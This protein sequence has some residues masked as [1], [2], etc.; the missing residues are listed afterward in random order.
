MN[1]I[2]KTYSNYEF[3][4]RM[5]SRDWILYKKEL[6]LFKRV[7]LNGTSF[8]LSFNYLYSDIKIKMDSFYEYE[9]EMCLLSFFKTRKKKK[10]NEKFIFNNTYI[11]RKKISNETIIFFESRLLILRENVKNTILVLKYLKL[12]LGLF[13]KYR[14]LKDSKNKISDSLPIYT[15]EDMQKHCLNCSKLF[16]PKRSN[17]IYCSDVCS[18]EFNKEKKKRLKEFDKDYIKTAIWKKQK[19][20][21]EK[22]NSCSIDCLIKEFGYIE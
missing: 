19:E 14:V 13:K 4:L 21:M 1:N 22:I 10:T 12:N 2:E 8:S 7:R 9:E 16:T 18:K 11:K 3:Y 6:Q 17:N 5:L 15:I 20:E